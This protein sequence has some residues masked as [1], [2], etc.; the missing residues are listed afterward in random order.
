MREDEGSLFLDVYLL[1]TNLF[2]RTNR[3]RVRGLVI[4]LMISADD[5]H[6]QVKS[7]LTAMKCYDIRYKMCM[8]YLTDE[9]KNST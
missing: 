1:N 6:W 3:S 4:F 2:A 5:C 8:T 9:F 7:P